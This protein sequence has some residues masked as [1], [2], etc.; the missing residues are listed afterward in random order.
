MSNKQQSARSARC[1]SVAALLASTVMIGSALGACAGGD[2]GT[3]IAEGTVESQGGEGFA[4][5]ELSATEDDGEVSGEA[6]VTRGE[7]QP[8]VTITFECSGEAA[9]GVVIV[10]GE[11]SESEDDEFPVGTPSAVLVKEG[12]PDRIGLWFEDPSAVASCSELIENIPEEDLSDP[13]SYLPVDGEI[14][15]G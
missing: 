5:M 4:T 15:T 6:K 9:D 3:T 14:K 10:G 7:S 1:L 12:D 11:V 13:S 2:G 8:P